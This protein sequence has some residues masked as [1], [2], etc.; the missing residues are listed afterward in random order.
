MNFIQNPVRI[1]LFNATK[2]WEDRLRIL[3]S[4]MHMDKIMSTENESWSLN[5]QTIPTWF[6]QMVFSMGIALVF[7]FA[8]ILFGS[9]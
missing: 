7:G 4:L 2:P 1:F 9:I 5:N 6:Y 8:L 3:E